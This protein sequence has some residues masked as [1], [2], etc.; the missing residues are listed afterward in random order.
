MPHA[1]HEV[2]KGSSIM[3]QR[4]QI[5]FLTEVLKQCDFALMAYGDVR[6]SLASL[7][8]MTRP[9]VDCHLRHMHRLWYSVQSFL[10]ATG[11]LSKLFWPASK[12]AQRGK[13]LRTV[14]GVADASSVSSR[15]FRNHFE[16]FDE[17]L[18][19]WISASHGM[20]VDSNVGPTTNAIAGGDS[21][22]YLRNYDNKA[23]ILTFLGDPLEVRP[24]VQE[25]SRIRDAAAQAL[26]ETHWRISPKPEVT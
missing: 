20:F 26:S 24:V 8:A 18:E 12:F 16:H 22:S 14:L 19:A 3:E 2:H 17:R 4:S 15:T 11:N 13:E 21:A 6:E 10:I 5:I 1:A 23:E 25:I 9:E 7:E